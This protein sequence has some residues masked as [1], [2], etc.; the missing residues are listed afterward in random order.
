MC[1]RGHGHSKNG[2]QGNYWWEWIPFWKMVWRFS[3]KLNIELPEDLNSTILGIHP[4]NGY[5]DVQDGSTVMLS[6]AQLIARKKWKQVKWLWH[7]CIEW[8]SSQMLS[9]DPNQ[10]LSLLLRRGLRSFCFTKM[11]RPDTGQL[12][13][14]H[15]SQICSPGSKLNC[16][17][18]QMFWL[19][20]SA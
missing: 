20:A 5:Q 10:Y 7:E 2:A 19:G 1:F 18:T 9:E 6:I 11:P 8:D 17:M 14:P 15:D 16:Q 4:N 3:K 12:W 13:A